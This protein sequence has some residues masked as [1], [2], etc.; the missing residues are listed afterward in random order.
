MRPFHLKAAD[1]NWTIPFVATTSL[2]IGSDPSIEA[3]LPAGT[4][5]VKRSQ[6]F[7]NLGTGSMIGTAGGF[8][9]AGSF[10]HDQHARETGVLS[11]EAL[12]NSLAVSSAI[13]LLSGRERPTQGG[14]KGKFWQGGDS[15][16]SDHAA[17]AWSVASLFAHEY[18]GPMTKL[19]A[20]GLASAVSAAR[21]T[22]DKHFAAD[23]FIGGALGWYMGREDY[24][25]H[26][27]PELD[28]RG[29]TVLPSS[30]AETRKPSNMGSPYVPLD[31]WVY[32]A[33]ERLN[34]LGY[35]QT[36]YL[37]LRPWT[38]ME[39]ARLVDE[40]QERMGD[41][42]AGNKEVSQLFAA[43]S[44]EF[45]DETARRSGAQNAGA[46][47]ESLYSRFTGISGTPLR[48]GYHFGQT[49]IN[50]FG[51]PYGEGLN[52]TEGFTSY[53]VAGPLAVAI[54]GEY[55]HAPALPTDAPSVLE[56]T[57]AADNTLPLANGTAEVNRIRLLNSS[58]GFTFNNVAFS[59]GQQSLWLGPT[60]AGP[61]LFSTNAAP[62]TML[63]VD[64]AT[65]YTIPL[66]SYLL[67]PV[68][69]QF[70]LGR[71]AGQNWE[72]SPTLFG[73][74]LTSQPWLEGISMSFH[75]TE[76]LEFGMGFTAQFGGEG[77]PFTWS[78]F[79]RTFYS[80]RESLATNPAKR[81]SEFNFD[82]RVPGL[83]DWLEV[84][85]DSM[86]IDEYSP[87]GSTRPS[88]NPGVYLP[89]LPRLH[90]FDLRLEG[91][92]TDLNWPSHFGP[93]AVYYDVR[94]RSGYTNDGNLIGSWIGRQGRGEQG[95]LT[96]SF[97]PRTYFQAEYRHNS[98]DREFLEG[99]DLQDFAL[100]GDVM[101][102]REL[103]LSG[104]VQ[105]EN[106]H[107]PVRSSAPKSDVT[108]S[109]QLTFWPNWKT[110]Q[111]Q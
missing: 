18:P 75:P 24:R 46:N 19:V 89:R 43:L 85:V 66:L 102:N 6:T 96:Y 35:L 105:H 31:S 48:D 34:A 68:R 111:N 72:A 55:Q 38:R 36:A 14:G 79:L 4:T 91:V 67:G 32:P 93:G 45:A 69:S 20:Y 99:G 30:D 63:R 28:G 62:V 7:S 52:S 64:S 10:I 58:V 41:G 61:F 49:I 60:E 107:F 71:L 33:F 37:G 77:N 101:L 27:N 110:R 44:D 12:V 76:N 73:P 82:Y 86:V 95:W 2:L 94:Y 70:F 39:C 74:S 16:P 3:R 83:R 17:A 42:S 103:S 54:Q 13:Q 98:I 22:G 80:H 9:L 92:T 53:A 56:A 8:Y 25:A 104:F 11:G 26:H 97:T 87:I 59:F 21:V 100:R 81:L 5:F 84:Y 109:L 108:A 40:A 50:D 29:W 78:S 1:S 15:F 57:A 106:W 23:V 90:K 51:R 65:P 47:L 88:I